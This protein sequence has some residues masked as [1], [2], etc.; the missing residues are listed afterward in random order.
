M[1]DT[2][3]SSGSESYSETDIKHVLGKIYDDFH[4]IDAREFSELENRPQRLKNLRDDLY[5][6]L[7]RKTLKA[8][9][10]RFSSGRTNEAIFY[11]VNSFG[12]IYNRDT[13]SGG[14]NYYKFPEDSKVRFIVRWDYSDAESNRYMEERGWTE[15]TSFL[16]GTAVNKGDY[17]RGNLSINKRMIRS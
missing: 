16:Q 7:K 1:T 12:S 3:T 8:F 11:E 9:E 5:F 6:L 10:I 2:Y 4:A 13:P 17:T 15:T 14:T